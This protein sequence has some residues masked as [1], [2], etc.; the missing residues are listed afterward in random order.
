MPEGPLYEEHEL[1][2]DDRVAAEMCIDFDASFVPTREVGWGKREGAVVFAM[3]M[4]D[5]G[6]GGRGARSLLR[7]N[8]PP[9]LPPSLPPS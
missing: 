1:I 6:E 7:L 3:G 5:G 2:W 8:G 4:R 9:S